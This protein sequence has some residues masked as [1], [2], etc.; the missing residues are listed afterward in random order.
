MTIWELKHHKTHYEQKIMASSL[1]LGEKTAAVSDIC[2]QRRNNIMFC[3]WTE[4]A[5]S[6]HLQG[7]FHFAEKICTTSGKVPYLSSLKCL[8][9]YKNLIQVEPFLIA[10]LY[11]VVCIPTSSDLY[12]CKISIHSFEM[13]YTPVA[14]DTRISTDGLKSAY[15][16]LDI[17]SLFKTS[18]STGTLLEIFLVCSSAQG[19]TPGIV[20]SSVKWA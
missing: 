4:E 6:I 14:Y 18:F 8:L 19:I 13:A 15:N 1:P 16:L 3:Y 17:L 7:S 9:S 5:V 2:K 10:T 20:V 11:V 12:N